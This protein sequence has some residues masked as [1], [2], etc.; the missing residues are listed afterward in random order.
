MKGEHVEEVY[1]YLSTQDAQVT[2]RSVAKR[3]EHPRVERED[4]VQDMALRCLEQAPMFRGGNIGA[5]AR[6][7][8]HR[9]ALNEIRRPT[10]TR[11]HYSFDEQYGRATQITPA[12]YA[13][14]SS[15]AAALWD[16]ANV[17]ERQLIVG[18]IAHE[19]R[20]GPYRAAIGGN[21]NT[22][23]GRRRRLKRRVKALSGQG[24]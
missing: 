11:T 4:L 8:A 14:A 19:G 17:N 1:N 23:Q 6:M 22:I 9:V 21:M 5:W 16:S 3:Y 13:E 20:T 10:N 7:V 12:H 2:F 18:L 15:V 24:D